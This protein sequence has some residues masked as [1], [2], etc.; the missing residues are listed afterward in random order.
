M[1]FSSCASHAHAPAYLLGIPHGKQSW[2]R[3]KGRSQRRL[4][5]REGKPLS[6]GVSVQPE[7]G[8]LKGKVKRERK[9]LGP[10]SGELLSGGKSGS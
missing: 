2:A 10:V 7:E 6:R 5:L 4:H 3:G 8:S 9:V 1:K